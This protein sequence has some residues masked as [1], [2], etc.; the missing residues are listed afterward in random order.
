[1]RIFTTSP[2]ICFVP[3]DIS[4]WAMFD[5]LSPKIEL[6][7]YFGSNIWNCQWCGY[8]ALAFIGDGK[9][10]FDVNID[11]PLAR[12]PWQNS[13]AGNLYQTLVTNF[14]LCF[15]PKQ[16]GAD[17]QWHIYENLKR[18]QNSVD[19]FVAVYCTLALL[20]VELGIDDILVDLIRLSLALQ[21]RPKNVWLA[22]GYI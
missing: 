18:P 10:S 21:V 5:I 13:N 6:I 3:N 11:I 15:L 8:T 4:S 14:L 2:K 20:V 7:G 9:V 17:I 12:Q 16:N 19:N 1:M 22:M